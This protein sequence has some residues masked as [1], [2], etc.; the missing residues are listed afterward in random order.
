[1]PQGEKG[2]FVRIQAEL[3][4]KIKAIAA[5]D[6][7]PLYKITDNAFEKYVESRNIQINKK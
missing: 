2:F 4:N 5:I 3:Y 1:M 6:G 7:V